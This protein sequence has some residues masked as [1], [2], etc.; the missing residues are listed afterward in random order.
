VLAWADYLNDAREAVKGWRA[1]SAATEAP[2]WED[3]ADIFMED[4]GELKWRVQGM[5]IEKSLCVVAA[6]PKASKTWLLL[7]LAIAQATC[8]K[9]FGRLRGG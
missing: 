2:Q 1:R 9:A 3:A 4:F 8:T 6:D 7:E 5:L